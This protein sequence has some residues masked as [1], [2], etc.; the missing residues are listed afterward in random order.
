MVPANH[1]FTG[2]GGRVS[3]PVLQCLPAPFLR[4][5]GQ[6]PDGEGNA[7]CY[8]KVP[9]TGRFCRAPAALASSVFYQQSEYLKIWEALAKRFSIFF[10]KLP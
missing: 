5:V 6:L 10:F 3:V 9:V 7:W 1:T 4:I 8:N 2:G